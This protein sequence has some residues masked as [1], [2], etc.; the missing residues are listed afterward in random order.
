MQVINTVEIH[1]LSMPSKRS[2]PHAKIEV[3]SI[4]SFNGYAA[5]ILHNI[6]DRV[7]SANIPRI[8]VLQNTS[9]VLNNQYEELNH[10]TKTS[11]RKL[12]VMLAIKWHTTTSHFLA[13]LKLS[14]GSPKPSFSIVL[15]YIP[16]LYQ[17]V[18]EVTSQYRK[19]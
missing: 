18:K 11:H 10:T 16:I 19:D 13:Q 9:L 6:Q 3:R 12:S 4:H 17:T 5:L 15:P 7:Q 8:H 2:F 14:A 1:V